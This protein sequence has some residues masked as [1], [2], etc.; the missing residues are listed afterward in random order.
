MPRP[1]GS[2]ITVTGQIA[3]KVKF[4]ASLGKPAA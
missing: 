1:A 2:Q 4:K 3:M